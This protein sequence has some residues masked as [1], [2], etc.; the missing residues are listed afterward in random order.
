MTR[1]QRGSKRFRKQRTQKRG[2][3]KFTTAAKGVVGLMALGAAS[4]P[5]KFSLPKQPGNL[6]DYVMKKELVQPN[7][8]PFVEEGMK[9]YAKNVAASAVSNWRV[10]PREQYVQAPPLTDDESKHMQHY[11][12]ESAKQEMYATANDI[13]MEWAERE[14]L[15]SGF[16]NVGNYLISR[17]KELD[18]DK[19]AIVKTGILRYIKSIAKQFDVETFLAKFKGGVTELTPQ[20]QQT[21]TTYKDSVILGIRLGRKQTQ[22]DPKLITESV[23]EAYHLFMIVDTSNG[24][25]RIEKSAVLELKPMNGDYS[26]QASEWLDMTDDVVR[27]TPYM[28]FGELIEATQQQMGDKFLTYDAKENNCQNFVANLLQVAHVWDDKSE[29]FVL[30]DTSGISDTEAKRAQAATTVFSRGVNALNGAWNQKM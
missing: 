15:H 4:A 21:L 9:T 10:D 5:N 3:T 17:Y 6:E 1:R 27:E 16:R 2:G 19:S 22:I 25:L 7:A 13:M 26:D 23:D 30:Q 28:T 24:P 8:E 29:K 14:D 12:W 20:F 18:Q 11:V